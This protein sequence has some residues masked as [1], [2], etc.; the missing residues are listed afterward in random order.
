MSILCF[1]LYCK[2]SRDESP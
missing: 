1:E 2:C